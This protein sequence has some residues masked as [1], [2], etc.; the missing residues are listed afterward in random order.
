MFHDGIA[1][2]AICGDP[3]SLILFYYVCSIDILTYFA[4]NL[5]FTTKVII[6]WAS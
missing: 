6:A 5:D 1:G 2:L 4:L 3:F